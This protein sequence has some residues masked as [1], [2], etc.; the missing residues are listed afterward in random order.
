ML[1]KLHLSYISHICT[2]TGHFSVYTYVQYI[3]Q[4]KLHSYRYKRCT[5]ISDLD[6]F[7]ALGNLSHTLYPFYYLYILFIVRITHRFLGGCISLNCT[8]KLWIVNLDWLH[9]SGLTGVQKNHIFWRGKQG[10][11]SSEQLLLDFL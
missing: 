11:G 1:S 9:V 5:D 4:R 2:Q 7:H 6:Y 8:I 10:K 3:L